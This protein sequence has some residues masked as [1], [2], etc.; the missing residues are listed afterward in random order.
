MSHPGCLPFPCGLFPGVECFILRGF[1]GLE[2][3][4]LALKKSG[5]GGW[6]ILL[7]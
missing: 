7:I 5:L 6:D 1:A 2:H 3:M 4:L